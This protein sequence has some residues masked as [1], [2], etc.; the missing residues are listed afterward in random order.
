MFAYSISFNF[1]CYV[2]FLKSNRNCEIVKRGSYLGLKAN[3]IRHIDDD[4]QWFDSQLVR[5]LHNTNI[6]YIAAAPSASSSS[7]TASSSAAATLIFTH[8]ASINFL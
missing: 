3:S 2:T 6:A 1:L 8:P 7:T 4:Y 5:K